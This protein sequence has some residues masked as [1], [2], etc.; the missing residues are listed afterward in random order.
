[1]IIV[2]SLAFLL[3]ALSVEPSMSLTP[4]YPYPDEHLLCTYSDFQRG[5]V[6][7]F[8]WFVNNAQVGRLVTDKQSTILSQA[9]KRLDIIRCQINVL[10]PATQERN[11]PVGSKT[12]TVGQFQCNDGID[13]D[14]D[15]LIDALDTGCTARNDKIEAVAN[16]SQIF[17]NFCGNHSN[18][19]QC[20]GLGLNDINALCDAHPDNHFCQNRE[21]MNLINSFCPQN[22]NDPIC[23]GYRNIVHSCT[24]EPNDLGCHF[25]GFTIVSC[26][27]GNCLELSEN[28]KTQLCNLKA[29]HFCVAAAEFHAN[30]GHVGEPCFEGSCFEG[31]CNA[32]N[33]CEEARV[34][35]NPGFIGNPCFEGACFEGACNQDQLCVAVVLAEKPPFVPPAGHN[36]APEK[37]K[38]NESSKAVQPPLVKPEQPQNLTPITK[39]EIVVK[40]P[41][42]CGNTI[43]EEYEQK[44]CPQDCPT[45][46][47]GGITST[48]LL[49]G[50]VVLAAVAVGYAGYRAFGKKKKGKKGNNSMLEK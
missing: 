10:D 27:Q 17:S 26:S 34:E 4:S 47:Q 11:F 37:P 32:Q 2:L 24:L 5:N 16:L 12:A 30:P 44:T 20:L 49:A 19:F 13:N 46:G 18:N 6:L 25:L 45:T 14:H 39:K 38:Q 1:M 31:V 42:V 21:V 35:F 36:Q 33:V 50:L 3:S 40:L 8:M 22:R 29:Y 9:T 48:P 41:P 15:G 23:A 7:E 43:C 28:D